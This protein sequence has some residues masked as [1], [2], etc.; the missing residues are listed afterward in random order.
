MPSKGL[1]LSPIGWQLFAPGDSPND[2]I[3]SQSS[4]DTFATRLLARPLRGRR[5]LRLLGGGDDER[6][7]TSLAVA[8]PQARLFLPTNRVQAAREY[9]P[10]MEEPWHPRPRTCA[11]T[12]KGPIT[13]PVHRICSLPPGAAVPLKASWSTWR[14]CRP[15][16]SSPT[17]TRS[18]R[19]WRT[20]RARTS[21]GRHRPGSLPRPE[22][23][24]RRTRQ[25][26]RPE[27]TAARPGGG[28][29][30]LP[31]TRQRVAEAF[32]RVPSETRPLWAKRGL[33]ISAA[34]LFAAGLLVAD[35]PVA[36]RR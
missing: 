13:Q 6:K 36:S 12:S 9:T 24:R 5:A 2:W 29:S 15:T 32:E 1:E 27:A 17:P 22:Q 10:Y 18:P 30:E 3:A 28:R 20:R 26:C 31:W 35:G 19:S 23:N 4:V 7:I 11:S 16:L 8:A 21:R 14:D 25:A 34:L 33:S